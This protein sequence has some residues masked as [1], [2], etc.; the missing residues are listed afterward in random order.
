MTDFVDINLDDT[1]EPYVIEAGK[2]VK[3]RIVK[4][5]KRMNKNEEPFLFPRFEV[6][7]EVAAKEFTKYLPLPLDSD[8]PKDKNSKKAAIKAFY[9]CFGISTSG[10]VGLEDQVGKTGWAILGVSEDP[11]YGEQNYVKKFVK[12][13]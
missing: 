7:G 2:E 6:D 9:E 8:S 12:G 11:E 10:S 13:N 3:L 4:L 1:V 5:E